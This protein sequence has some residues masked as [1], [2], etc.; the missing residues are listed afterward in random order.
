MT[1]AWRLT[2]SAE[3]TLIDMASWTFETC[4][5]RQAAAYE[6]DLIAVCRDIAAATATSRACREFRDP[7]LPE[8]LS[9]A[10][11]GRQFI[12]F[13]EDA[14]QVVIIDFLHAPGRPAS[15]ACQPAGPRGL[16][17]WLRLSEQILVAL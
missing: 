17:R 3:D 9:F 12:I 5:P 15:P 1:R 6:E 13:I 11:A 10:R 14:E 8:G 2:K 16:L 7:D 4:G